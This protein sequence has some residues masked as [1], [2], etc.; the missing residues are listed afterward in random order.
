MRS[1]IL[2]KHF[3]QGSERLL[4]S[5]RLALKKI[6]STPYHSALSRFSYPILFV[7]C[8]CLFVCSFSKQV[9]LSTISSSLNSLRQMSLYEHRGDYVF[10]RNCVSYNKETIRACEIFSQLFQIF[11]FLEDERL[12]T[13]VLELV[14]TFSHFCD[15]VYDGVETVPSHTT[16]E[17][18]LSQS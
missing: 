6:E 2:R 12:Q 9:F 3:F 16:A 14:R 1:C 4:S 18:S 8:F 15:S 7:L 10:S 13:N 11:L 17:A 5:H